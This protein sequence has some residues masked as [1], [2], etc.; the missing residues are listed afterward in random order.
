MASWRISFAR[1]GAFAAI[2]LTAAA[3]NSI[4]VR[5]LAGMAA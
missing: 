2:A 5:F 1:T 3:F 4:S